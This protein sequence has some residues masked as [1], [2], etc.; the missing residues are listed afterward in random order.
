[1][2]LNSTVYAYL[3]GRWVHQHDSEL[4]INAPASDQPFLE[5]RTNDQCITEL[6]IQRNN[7]R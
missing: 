4:R 1:M 6:R 3:V 2:Y 5:F 7:T